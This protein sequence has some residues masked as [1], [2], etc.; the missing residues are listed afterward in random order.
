MSTAATA[1]DACGGTADPHVAITACLA[2][3]ARNVPAHEVFARLRAIEPAA[4]AP[5][6]RQ[7]FLLARGIAN[8]RLALR[9]EALGD[10]EEAR[11]LADAHADRDALGEILRNIAAVHNWRADWREAAL[12]LLDAVAEGANSNDVTAIALALIEA[13]R[14]QMEIGRPRGAQF[15]LRRSL[16]IAGADLSARERVRASVALLQALTAASLTEEARAHLATLRPLPSDSTPRLELLIEIE[17]AAVARASGDFAAARA[18]LA[19]AAALVPPHPDC[20]ERVE[21]DHAEAELALAAGDAARAVEL[22]EPVVSR[23]AT[24]DLAG[25]EVAAR[26]LHARALD[27]IGR[28]EQAQSTL[29]AALRR[30][31]AR[32]LSG[33]ADQVRS[34][35]AARGDVEGGWQPGEGVAGVP[36]REVGR[37]FVRQRPLGTGGFGYVARAYDLEL[38]VEVAL[39]RIKLGQLYDPAMRERLLDSARTEIAAASRIDHPGVARL[40][41]LLVEPGG[42]ALL[43]EELIEGPTLRAVL[44]QPLKRVQALDLLARIAMAL[45]AVHAANV[46]HRDLKP[47]NIILRSGTSPVIVDFGIALIGGAPAIGKGGTRSYM[48]PEQARGDAV[49]ARADLYSLGVIAHELLTGRLPDA[50]PAFDFPWSPWSGRKKLVA[51]GLEPGLADL[52]NRMLAGRRARRPRSV[53]VVAAYFGEAATQAAASAS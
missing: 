37:R 39:K 26:L 6:Q 11:R 52:I 7:L 27:Q 18:A 2:D 13:G 24:D 48:A 50:P 33:H 10:L 46:I 30:A 28:T 20:F 17:A 53:S 42:D 35:I 21:V 44:E 49:D 32:G 40:H 41:G 9:G 36:A 23:Y 12:T 19:R 8:N 22:L 1:T 4:T 43:V 14:L 16:G 31:L 47:D 34:R 25:R 51:A 29:A 45:A 3:L 38:G 5:A 15:L